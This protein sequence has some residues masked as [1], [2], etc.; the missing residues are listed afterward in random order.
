M[1]WKN[2]NEAYLKALTATG[3]KVKNGCN[4][5]LSIGSY[6]DKKEIFDSVELLSNSGFKLYGTMEQLIIIVNVVL[7]LLV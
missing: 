6:Q 5:L 2:Y 3:F 7:M 1:F 4:V